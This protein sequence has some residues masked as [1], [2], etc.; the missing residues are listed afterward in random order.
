MR[1]S[2]RS[3][4]DA[5]EEKKEKRK[6]PL[7]VLVP[8]NTGRGGNASLTEAVREALRSVRNGYL[9]GPLGVLRIHEAAVLY[10][11]PPHREGRQAEGGAPLVGHAPNLSTN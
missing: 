6:R 8:S 10:Y 9:G 4:D 5:R 2:N 1:C 7:L 11:E 3:G